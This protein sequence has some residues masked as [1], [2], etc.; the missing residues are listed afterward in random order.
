[1]ADMR[2]ELAGMDG[3]VAR[4]ASE[5]IP[6][7]KGFWFAGTRTPRALNRLA[8]MGLAKIDLMEHAGA[9]WWVY[10]ITPAGLK[11]L[12]QPPSSS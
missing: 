12:Q 5:F 2:Q 9:S 7:G 10:E 4:D 8:E 1:M 3:V 11:R 6:K